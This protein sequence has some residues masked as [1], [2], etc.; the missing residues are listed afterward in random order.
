MLSVNL[1]PFKNENGSQQMLQE[2]HDDTVRS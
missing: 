2:T 1:P